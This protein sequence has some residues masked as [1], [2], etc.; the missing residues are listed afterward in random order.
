MFGRLRSR[1][2]HRLGF[3]YAKVPSHQIPWSQETNHIS[4]H[5]AYLRL[6]WRGR[7]QALIS[8]RIFIAS[9]LCTNVKVDRFKMQHVVSILPPGLTIDRTPEERK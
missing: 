9:A 1:L 3:G 7:L 4:E 5:A 6:T 8:G 2:W